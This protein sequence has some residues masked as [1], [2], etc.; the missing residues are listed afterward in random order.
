MRSPTAVTQALADPST[1]S[2]GK[3]KSQTRALSSSKSVAGQ[4][5]NY[6]LGNLCQRLTSGTSHVRINTLNRK[7][8]WYYQQFLNHVVTE[9]SKA[10]N[11]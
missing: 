9:K 10:G 1:T 5:F 11:L 8:L 7:T 3:D 2:S 4:Q 6:G